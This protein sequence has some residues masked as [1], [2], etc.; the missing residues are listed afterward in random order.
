MSKPVLVGRLVD[1]GK[2]F[3]YPYTDEQERQILAERKRE[4]ERASREEF[5]QLK[6][7]ARKAFAGTHQLEDR[8]KG[9]ALAWSREYMIHPEQIEN[10]GFEHKPV[11]VALCGML[12]SLRIREAMSR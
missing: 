9:V 7:M 12:R 3:P 11:L 10:M 6:A 1:Y 2:E 4:Q 8:A 5:E